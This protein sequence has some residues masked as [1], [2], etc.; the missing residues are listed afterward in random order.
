MNNITRNLSRFGIL[1]LVS[2]AAMA[3]RPWQP[4]TTPT[5]LG[6]RQES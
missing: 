5:V 2:F 3:Q 1:F 6:A 4:M